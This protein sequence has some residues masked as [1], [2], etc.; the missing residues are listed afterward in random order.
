[1]IPSAEGALIVVLLVANPGHISVEQRRLRVVGV[2]LIAL[3]T[4]VN[5]ISLT[6]LIHALL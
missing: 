2:A 5:V 1:M 4:F 6:E 3:I